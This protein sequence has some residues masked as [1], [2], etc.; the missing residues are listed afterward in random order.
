[1]KRIAS[2]GALKGKETN[3]SVQK[4]MITS[5]ASS[6]IPGMH[7]VQLSGHRNVQSLNS[8]QQDTGNLATQVQNNHKEPGVSCIRNYL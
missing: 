4:P 3:H 6:N 1:M 5:L 8:Y 7:M 2:E